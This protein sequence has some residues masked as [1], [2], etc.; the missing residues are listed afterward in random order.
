MIR[1]H[2]LVNERALALLNKL[3]ASAQDNFLSQQLNDQADQLVA[4][5]GQLNGGA[6]DRR[7][8]ENEL[9]YHQAVNGLVEGTFI[10]NL[11]NSEVHTLLNTLLNDFEWLQ[12]P[13]GLRDLEWLQA[14]IPTGAPTDSTRLPEPHTRCVRW[15]VGLGWTR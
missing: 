9:G 7:Y 11:Q 13:E 5:M 15:W 6:F 1:D 12:D 14:P 10:P 2:S 8:A 3:G 4:E